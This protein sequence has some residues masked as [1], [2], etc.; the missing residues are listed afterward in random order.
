MPG[1]A[2]D[3]LV[4]TPERDFP[5][6]T[7][8]VNR[9]F[10]EGLGCLHLR[11]PEKSGAELMRYL[12]KIDEQYHANIMVHYREE[13]RQEIKVK[14][15]HYRYPELPREKPEFVV[16]CGC[17]SWQEF[18]E[19]E[20]RV[21]YA[22]ISP[23][24]PSISKKGYAAKNELWEI[25]PNVNLGKVVALG[26]VNQGNIQQVRELR[27]KGAAVLG[28]VWE[29]SDPLRAFEELKARICRGFRE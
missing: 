9:L 29:A 3:L 19:V 17:H 26:G 25:P 22:F 13:L 2:F 23:F 4:I 6:E 1:Q 15:I 20:K 12:E 14:G 27:L 28:A 10:A 8:W 24:Y 18:Q 21:D 5:E 16:S 11:K 7:L